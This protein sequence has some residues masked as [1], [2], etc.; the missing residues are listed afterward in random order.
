MTDTNDLVNKLTKDEITIA[1]E[2]A[3][4]DMSDKPYRMTEEEIVE[5]YAHL[6][7][8]RSHPVVHQKIADAAQD[9]M[10]KLGHKSP[11]QV[12]LIIT[13]SLE[14]VKKSI[15]ETERLDNEK[16]KAYLNS[17]EVREMVAKELLRN[18]LPDKGGDIDISLFWL[19]NTNRIYYLDFATSLLAKIAEVIK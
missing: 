15:K 16:F 12:D 10:I 1:L 3:G 6:S 14:I 18:D 19:N 11:E 13:N 2:E 5:S 9:K 8:P 4:L 17:P 7:Q